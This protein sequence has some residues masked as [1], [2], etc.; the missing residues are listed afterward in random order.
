M[1]VIYLHS[2]DGNTIINHIQ[3]TKLE[4]SKTYLRISYSETFV[5]IKKWNYGISTTWSN[6]KPHNTIE[7][8]FVLV[9]VQQQPYQKFTLAGPVTI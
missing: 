5:E 2:I 6:Y 8:L 1:F 9:P 3:K 7:F 4:I